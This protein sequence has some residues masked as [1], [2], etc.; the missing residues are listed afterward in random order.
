MKL[1]KR[2][3]D[4][5]TTWQLIA[6]DLFMPAP[7]STR[8]PGIIDRCTASNLDPYCDSRWRI[9]FAGTHHHYCSRPDDFEC[10]SRCREWMPCPTPVVIAAMRE[11]RLKRGSIYDEMVRFLSAC[12]CKYSLE[13]GEDGCTARALRGKAEWQTV[14]NYTESIEHDD[15]RQHQRARAQMRLYE[16]VARE[17]VIWQSSFE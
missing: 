1:R 12:V 13:V 10:V 2:D 9:P 4:D 16:R 14:D 7:H 15:W 11:P 5:P 17:W 6:S 8:Y 3:G